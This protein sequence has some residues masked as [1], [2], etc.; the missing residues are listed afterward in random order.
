[1]THHVHPYIFRIG[2]LTTWKS[3]WFQSKNFAKYLR[4]DTLVREWLLMKLR[5]CHIESIDIER[6]A[7]TM[8]IIIKT[9]RPGLL[10]GRSG[11][12]AEKLKNEI[13]SRLLKIA[14]RFKDASPTREIK[15]TV[16]EV[17]SPESHAAIAAQMVA[18]ELE[19][20]VQFRRALKQSLAKISA[21]PNVQGVKIALSGRLDGSEMARHEWVKNGRIPL[22]TIRANID[23]AHRTAYTTYGTIGIR[24]WIYKG[25]VFE[26]KED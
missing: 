16:E 14:R 10:I 11:E 9:S 5:S 15:L 21:A 22:Q 2:Q 4:E 12:G 24:I 23:Y 26:K 7:N 6:F 1:M 18:D 13:E 19:K 20:R 3:R 8:H 17:R 25:D